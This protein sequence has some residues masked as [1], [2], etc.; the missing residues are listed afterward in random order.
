MLCRAYK[1]MG[2]R[3]E[4]DDLTTM[5]SPSPRDLLA[6]DRLREVKGVGAYAARPALVLSQ[7]RYG[8]LP[9]DR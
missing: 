9:L 1:L 4:L 5:A 7:R 2:K 3:V 6:E 8:L